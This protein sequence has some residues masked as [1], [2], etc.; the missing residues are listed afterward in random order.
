MSEDTPP[1]S[2]TQPKRLGLR[3]LVMALGVWSTLFLGVA[4]LGVYYML[5]ARE[6]S[7]VALALSC[8]ALSVSIK[9]YGILTS[10]R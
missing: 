4:A 3:S 10:P 7:L 5:A 1:Y 2:A 8:F 9:C 6:L